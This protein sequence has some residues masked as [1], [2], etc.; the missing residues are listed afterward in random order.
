MDSTETNPPH[1]KRVEFD[2]DSQSRVKKGVN[3]PV[4]API[5]TK[6]GQQHEQPKRVH[7]LVNPFSGKRKGRK[8]AEYVTSQLVS[9]GL[10]VEAHYSQ[11]SG[12]LITLAGE[13]D[14]EF[15]DIIASVGGD[16]SFSEVLTGRMQI[17]PEGEEIFAVIP[18]G[19]GNSMAFDLGLNGVDSAI[20]TIIGGK[21]QAL[22]LARVELIEGLPGAEKEKIV[23]YSHNL[24]TWGLG[25]DSNIKAE[26][27][28]WMGPIRYDIGILMAIMA[29]KRRNAT[30][31]LDG[32]EISDDFTLFLIQNSQTGGSELPLAP[33][34]SLDDGKMDIGIL[35]KMH[36]RGILKAFGMLKSEGRH[37]FHPH[38]DYHQFTRLEITTQVPT[39]I[40]IDGEN[41]GSTPLVMDVLPSAVKV[42]APSSKREV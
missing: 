30:L 20:D 6:K 37:V 27:M 15:G 5:F 42:M 32:V 10:K 21:K 33:G 34:A 38:V 1:P 28:R 41:L 36:R 12:H 31:T 13:L 2:I 22:D 3:K 19:T 7:L 25:V 11:Y 29:N 40:N 26:K 24:V 4:F 23:R 39:A 16:G 35:K 18:A 17:N 14:V 8:V 9:K